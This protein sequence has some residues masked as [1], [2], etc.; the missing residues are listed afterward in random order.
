[1]SRPD[2][3][4]DIQTRIS[5]GTINFEEES[6]ETEG[7]MSKTSSTEYASQIGKKNIETWISDESTTDYESQ[8]EY[9]LKAKKGS[10]QEKWQSEKEDLVSGLKGKK[11]PRGKNK[12]KSSI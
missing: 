1:M 5:D 3:R 7:D 12:N 10:G 8:V 6:E 9:L 4:L 2:S 11:Y